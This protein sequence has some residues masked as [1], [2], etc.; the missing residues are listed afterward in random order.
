MPIFKHKSCLSAFILSSP[1]NEVMCIKFTAHHSVMGHKT[2]PSPAEAW[3][4]RTS[5][6]VETTLSTH[7]SIFAYN[8]APLWLNFLAC[9]RNT[10]Q[11]VSLVRQLLISQ[12]GSWS[13][14]GNWQ[15]RCK[16][17]CA[18]KQ[19]RTRV[20]ARTYQGKKVKV[21]GRLLYTFKAAEWNRH[22]P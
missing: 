19:E 11:K 13:S 22:S 4:T 15:M 3:T 20:R 17:T 7:P 10:L 1:S 18:T 12:S 8:A 9:D 21:W 6:T 14:A 5:W 2:R 16:D